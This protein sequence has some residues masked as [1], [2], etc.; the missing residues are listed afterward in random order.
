MGS[1]AKRAPAYRNNLLYYCYYEADGWREKEILTKKSNASVINGA[2]NLLAKERWR[3]LATKEAMDD[4]TNVHPH[5]YTGVA[6]WYPGEYV[7]GLYPRL[8]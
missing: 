2:V 1:L 7:S 3:E 5:L 4:S 8:P 6:L